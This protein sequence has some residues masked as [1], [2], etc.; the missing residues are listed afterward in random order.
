MQVL[1]LSKFVCNTCT[2]IWEEDQKQH[3]TSSVVCSLLY[4]SEVLLG[5]LEAI[6]STELFFWLH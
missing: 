3:W 2:K 4:P 1:L 6:N 5:V